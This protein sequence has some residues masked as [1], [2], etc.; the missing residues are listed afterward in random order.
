MP[1][2][3]L[4]LVAKDVVDYKTTNYCYEILTDESKMHF[5][6]KAAKYC[7]L[8][9]AFDC[10]SKQYMFY[11]GIRKRFQK[12]LEAKF[13]M[14]LAFDENNLLFDKAVERVYYGEW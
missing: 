10:S 6:V 13:C 4:N 1:K 2:L 7:L 11:P 14:S 12:L 9:G 8:D 3:N 5:A